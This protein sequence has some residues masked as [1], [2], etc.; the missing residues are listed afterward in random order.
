MHRVA[1]IV[2]QTA[3]M[4]GLEGTLNYEF[5]RYPVTE[6]DSDLFRWSEQELS[7]IGDQI[8]GGGLQHQPAPVMA[9]EDFSFYAKQVPGCFFFLGGGGQSGLHS[10]TLILDE[11]LMPAGSALLA[12]LAV[13]RLAAA[14]SSSR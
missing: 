2:A 9:A 10:D 11:D 7:S 3:D 13:R 5:A 1:Q 12:H 4:F 14:F 6:N 8:P